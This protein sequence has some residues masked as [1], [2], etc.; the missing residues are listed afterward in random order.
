MTNDSFDPPVIR[1]QFQYQPAAEACAPDAQSIFID[2]DVDREPRQ[3]IAIIFD[4]CGRDRLAAR[5]ST[6]I[7][8]IAVVE[9]QRSNSCC[10]KGLGK[11]LNIH[12]LHDAQTMSHG[13]T[14][15]RAIALGAIEPR[16]TIDA[17]TL[18]FDRCLV[19][20]HW[21]AFYV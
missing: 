21:T 17:T 15:K 3:R 10:S 11:G 20:A 19:E 13:H 14:W 4:L 18:K 2:V 6:A 8:P 9:Q 16:R 12:F 5:L 7:S 1:T